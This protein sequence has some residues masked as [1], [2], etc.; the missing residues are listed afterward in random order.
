[1]AIVVE[2]TAG[3]NGVLPSDS[4]AGSASEDRA[5]DVS[6]ARSPADEADEV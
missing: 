6:D 4:P 1:V 3:G 2:G 5:V